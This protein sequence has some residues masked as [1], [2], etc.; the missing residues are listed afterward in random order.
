MRAHKPI[1]S[2]LNKQGIKAIESD[3]EE[4]KQ[5]KTRRIFDNPGLL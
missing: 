3:L 1:F 5:I 4:E 2:N